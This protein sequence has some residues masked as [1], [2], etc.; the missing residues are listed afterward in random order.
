MKLTRAGELEWI[1]VFWGGR[2]EVKGRYCT[3]A[4][5]GW[6]RVGLVPAGA[7]VMCMTQGR[8]MNQSTSVSCALI[9]TDLNRVQAGRPEEARY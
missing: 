2:V 1:E 7:Y 6:L 4:G 9:S 8:S 5:G 3:A